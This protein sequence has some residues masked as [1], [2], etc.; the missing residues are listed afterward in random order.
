MPGPWED[1]T[2]SLYGPV[3][4]A[5]YDP[6]LAWGE[7]AGMRELRRAVLAD[8]HGH[9]LEIGAGTGL[10][11]PA[12]PPGAERLTL[13][14]PEASM[15]RR[16]RG[17]GGDRAVVA[18]GAEELPFEDDAFD[19]VVSTLVLCTV[20]DPD[21]SL[22]EIRR[23]LRPG[24]SLLLIEHVRS[25]RPGLARLQDLLHR[26]WR[27]VGHGCVCNRDT[28]AALTRADFDVSGLRRARWRRMPAIVAPLV[29]GTAR[30]TGASQ[31][32]G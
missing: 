14:D 26:P 22:R 21:R 28:V 31:G 6:L 19:T 1:R 8:A 17:V 20:Q 12:Y 13:A 9:V 10:N 27:A 32:A 4:T 18:A 16:L 2:V 29:A 5:L 7:R 3:F 30:A 25:S 11:L 24:G 15:V 23:V